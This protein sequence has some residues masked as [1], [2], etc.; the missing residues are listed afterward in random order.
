MRCGLFTDGLMHLR[1]DAMAAWCV[2]RGITDLELGAGGFSPA[3]HLDLDAL[4]AHD[5]ARTALLERL[6]AAGCRIAALNASGNPLHPD[7]ATAVPHDR[8]LRGAIELAPMLGVDRVVAMSGCPGAPGG[9]GR[10]PVFAGGAWLPDMEG[11]W[12]WQWEHVTS[13]WRDLT[14]WAS[15]VAPAVTICLELHP[16]ASVYNPASFELLRGQTAANLAVNLDPSHFWWQGIDPV[17]AVRALGSAIAY[18][19]GKD[20]LIRHEQVARNGVLDFAWPDRVPD[21]LPW[22]FAAVGS[23]HDL[24]DWRT[25]LAAVAGEGYDGVVSIEHEDPRLTPE[26]GIEKSLRAL[27]EAF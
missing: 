2:D 8:A 6:E 18:V 5:G 27:G 25:L 23:G 11:L 21:D 4:L 9:D 16:G 10:W 20:T 13:Y 22:H 14:A 15:A 3:P 19:H 24:G 1:L 7:P 12:R 17:E 26:E